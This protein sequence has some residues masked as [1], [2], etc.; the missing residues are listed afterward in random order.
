[1]KAN[2]ILTTLLLIVFFL[3]ALYCGIKLCDYWLEGQRSDTV[4]EGLNQYVS[5]PEDALEET[6]ASEEA[7]GEKPTENAGNS[8]VSAETQEKVKPK[9]VSYPVVDFNSLSAI[10]SDVIGWIYNGAKINYPIVQGDDNSFYVNHMYDKRENKNGCIFLDYRNSSDFSD[11]NSI[12]Y[13]HSMK[14]GSMFRTVLNY[15]DQEYYDKHP[16]FVITTPE[17]KYRISVF[18]GYVTS[19][20]DDAWKLDFADDADKT[21]WINGRIQ[22]SYFASDVVPSASDQIVTLSTCSYEFDNAFFVLFGAMTKEQ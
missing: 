19:E 4:Y 10:N 15:K 18:A 22:K 11:F 5:I 20:G 14:N 21:A 3:V 8:S 6:L 17:G 1:M 9:P 13:G 7:S 16:E 2:K 12:L